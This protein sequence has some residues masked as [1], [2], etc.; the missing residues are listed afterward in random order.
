MYASRAEVEKAPQAKIE[1][2]TPDRVTVSLEGGRYRFHFNKTGDVA[3]GMLG[4]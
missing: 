1:E 2:E 4:Q 3:W